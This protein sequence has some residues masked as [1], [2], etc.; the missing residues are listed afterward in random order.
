MRINGLDEDDKLFKEFQKKFV[1]GV[2]T[3]E[4]WAWIQ[5]KITFVTDNSEEFVETCM[6]DGSLND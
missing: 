4:F 2:E 1:D 6:K 5:K 3:D